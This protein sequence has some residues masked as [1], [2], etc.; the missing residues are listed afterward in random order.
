M[1]PN[2]HSPVAECLITANCRTPGLSARIRYEQTLLLQKLVER[3][4][5][6]TVERRINTTVEQKA[7]GKAL[8]DAYFKAKRKKGK[9]T[10]STGIPVGNVIPP[11]SGGT[12]GSSGKTT[13][14]QNVGGQSSDSSDMQ[15]N[16]FKCGGEH[17]SQTCK[18]TSPTAEQKAA[19]K[20]AKEA[21]YKAK[22]NKRKDTSSTGITQKTT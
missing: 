5:S 22:R 21:F 16:C 17:H 3:I 13:S 2:K 15:F 12:S 1:R 9:D 4:D 18:V 20:A 11:S 8:R 19:G 10:N 6:T 7:A 14:G